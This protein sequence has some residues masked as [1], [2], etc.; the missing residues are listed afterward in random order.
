MQHP[1]P[2]TTA[3]PLRQ[4]S[5]DLL[6]CHRRVPT[7]SS[8]TLSLA[9]FKGLQESCIITISSAEGMTLKSTPRIFLV[10]LTIHTA[11]D[12]NLT[13]LPSFLAIL[14]T[15]GS[16]IILPSP[17]TQYHPMKCRPLLSIWNVCSL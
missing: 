3:P 4:L 15:L 11:T 8:L 9:Q 1:R 17:A 7:L 2:I 5:K 6:W 14:S 12:S 13:G 10:A 16:L